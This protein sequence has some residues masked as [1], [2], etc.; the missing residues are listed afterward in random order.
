MP[1][2]K[3]LDLSRDVRKRYFVLLGILALM[4]VAGAITTWWSFDR[5]SAASSRLQG[6]LQQNENFLPVQVSVNRFADAVDEGSWERQLESKAELINELTV[7][8]MASKRNSESSQ[9]GERAHSTASQMLAQLNELHLSQIQS[10]APDTTSLAQHLSEQART[11]QQDFESDLRIQK[12]DVDALENQTYG[13]VILTLLGTAPAL[14]I[15]GIVLFEPLVVQIRARFELLEAVNKSSTGVLE[16]L[17]RE[18]RIPMTSI[19]GYADYL[20]EEGDL[21]RAPKHRVDAIQTIQRNG[22]YLVNLISDIIDIS[23]IESGEFK[24][25]DDEVSLPSLI[26]EAVASNRSQA[27]DKKLNLILDYQTDIPELI[28]VAPERFFQIISNLLSNAIEFTQSGNVTVKVRCPDKHHSKVEIDVVDTGLGMSQETIDGLFLPSLNACSPTDIHNGRTGLGLAISKRLALLMGGDLQL[29]ASVP[30]KGSCFR[31][32]LPLHDR[33]EENFIS[34]DELNGENEADS[35]SNEHSSPQAKSNRILLVE[36]GPDNQ[37]IISHILRKAGYEVEV[38]ENGLLG[39]DEATSA[40]RSASPYAL[41]LMDMQ[42]PVMDG[43]TATE[44][45]RSDGYSWPIVALTANALSGDREKCLRA[46]CN[47]FATK[48]IERDRLL[49]LV[50]DFV[51][52]NQSIEDQLTG[53]YGRC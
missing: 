36:D 9:L 40:A 37:K 53:V 12:A 50:S 11:F 20:L 24:L 5:W 15:S 34:S 42:M 2:T 22:R 10:E 47:A 28:R 14:I 49:N 8:R 29:V 16:N 25:I 41:I 44:F 23:R 21:E 31:L 18:I 27:K 13:V 46:G 45:L 33:S 3:H 7:W 1:V 35:T 48:P 6:L 39:V 19:I 4:L 51:H 17:S 52:R 38:V 26:D 32:S 30:R 43:Y